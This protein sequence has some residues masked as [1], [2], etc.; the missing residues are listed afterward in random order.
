MFALQW[1]SHYEKVDS[2]ILQNYYREPLLL[3]RMAKAQYANSLNEE[4]GISAMSNSSD[5]KGSKRDVSIPSQFNIA[6]IEQQLMKIR[7]NQTAVSAFVEGVLTRF[8]SREQ[9]RSIE[10][11]LEYL[12]LVIKHDEKV[13]ATRKG[14]AKLGTQDLEFSID[15]RRKEI[16]LER[17]NQELEAVKTGG[18]AE[19]PEAEEVEVKSRSEI[20]EEKAKEYEEN[21]AFEQRL[22]RIDEGI[23]E[24]DNEK[25]RQVHFNRLERILDDAHEKNLRIDNDTSLSDDARK[26]ARRAVEQ[27]MMKQLDDLLDDIG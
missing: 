11:L 25:Q 13:Y 21:Q 22:R 8:K 20:F 14:K 2:S 7:F 12:D 19:V 24:E 4:R 23:R 1:I 5:N 9:R 27:L 15:Q 18:L 26:E 6:E 10:E 3:L 16:E 17:L